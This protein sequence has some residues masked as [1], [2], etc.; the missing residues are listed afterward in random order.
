VFITASFDP[1]ETF[2]SFTPKLSAAEGAAAVA[3]E[4][5]RAERKSKSLREIVTKCLDEAQRHRMLRATIGQTLAADERR[6][7]DKLQQ[8]AIV[9]GVPTIFVLGTPPGGLAPLSPPSKDVKSPVSGGG[10]VTPTAVMSPTSPTPTVEAPV[11]VD[12]SPLSKDELTKLS[13]GILLTVEVL[14]QRKQ[15]LDDRIDALAKKLRELTLPLPT[16][17]KNRDDFQTKHF[18]KQRN[19]WSSD[20]MKAEFDRMDTI[21][22]NYE[23][24]IARETE[25]KVVNE[26]ELQPLLTHMKETVRKGSAIR[27]RVKTVL[28]SHFIFE[29]DRDTWEN[30]T[31]IQG[32]RLVMAELK[33]DSDP[34]FTSALI[35]HITR[36]EH[37]IEESRTRVVHAIDES[38]KQSESNHAILQANLTSLNATASAGVASSPQSSQSGL[39]LSG[40]TDSPS[41]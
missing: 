22:K 19:S 24:A 23:T 31:W 17:K 4:D 5:A 7:A 1:P 2:E 40:S 12:C 20:K 9:T 15:Y 39:D 28:K 14:F 32:I 29:A 8:I 6:V 10:S 21:V 3:A 13:E 18:D 34:H 25:K 16:H 11:T 33:R 41:Y 27:D 35:D 36:V 30:A 26:R 38:R 37:A